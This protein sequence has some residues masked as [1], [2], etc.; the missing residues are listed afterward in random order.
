MSL[1]QLEEG[2]KGGESVDPVERCR[3]GDVELAFVAGEVKLKVRTGLVGAP[4][5]VLVVV[6][7]KAGLDEP[8]VVENVS[9]K[10]VEL[11]DVADVLASVP[12]TE[13]EEESAEVGTEGDVEEVSEEPWVVELENERD[14]AL[15]I[16]PSRR[17]GMLHQFDSNRKRGQKGTDE[18]LTSALAQDH[19]LRVLDV[20]CSAVLLKTVECSLL[21][22]DICADTSCIPRWVDMSE[23]K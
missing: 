2:E 11:E 15:A 1:R 6:V 9:G 8:V 3:D 20:L 19:C 14:D 13:S 17:S 5:P 4:V 16:G 10:F 22:L 12:V 7:L 21:E 18:G 23:Q